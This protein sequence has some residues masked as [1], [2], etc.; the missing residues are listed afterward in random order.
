MGLVSFKR[1]WQKL[2]SISK[3]NLL[4]QK[5]LQLEAPK[6]EVLAIEGP[7]TSE[8]NEQN[9]AHNDGSKM[10]PQNKPEN[11]S[12]NATN[13]APENLQNGEVDLK[14]CNSLLN[15]RNVSLGKLQVFGLFDAWLLTQ[16][17]HNMVIC[18]WITWLC[19]Q[20]G[21]GMIGSK[22]DSTCCISKR[23]DFKFWKVHRIH[24]LEFRNRNWASNAWHF[25]EWRTS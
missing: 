5:T 1:M 10:S 18:V 16:I 4:V 12:N 20:E 8:A 9:N 2:K 11:T 7:K 22:F 24:S 25:K 17:L 6:K 13:G 19:Q 14:V 23:S 15:H 21:S 3:R